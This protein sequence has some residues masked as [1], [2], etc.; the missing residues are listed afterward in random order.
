MEHFENEL[1]TFLG[2]YRPGLSGVRELTR[3][4]H[5]V[6]QTRKALADA[7][8]GGTKSEHRKV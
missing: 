5:K 7:L 2:I 4:Y 8:P 6:P 3:V 1:A